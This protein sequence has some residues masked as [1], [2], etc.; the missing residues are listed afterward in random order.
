MV[1]VVLQTTPALGK[2]ASV[3]E[4]ISIGIMASPGFNSYMSGLSSDGDAAYAWLNAS[5][6]SKIRIND[7]WAV[8]PY[9]DA[10]LN[11]NGDADYN[12]TT[13]KNTL[14]VPSV[15]ARY[16]F[17]EDSTFYLQAGPSL[18]FANGGGEKAEFKGGGVGAAASFGYA[19]RPGIELDLGYNYTPVDSTRQSNGEKTTEDFGGPFLRV[20]FRF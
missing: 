16:S 17:R 5:I 19:F 4:G 9:L 6:S 18:V 7:N 3:R 2:E 10:Y 14:V 12:G 11:G 15:N 20:G 8:V 13:S 1:G